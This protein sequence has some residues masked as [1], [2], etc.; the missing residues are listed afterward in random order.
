[1]QA[2]KYALSATA[3]LKNRLLGARQPLSVS[4]TVTNRCNKKCAYCKVWDTK[5]KELGTEEALGVIDELG[6]MGCQR[7]GLTGGE[8][9]LRED[10][11]ELIAQAK[12]NGIFTGLVT[13]GSLVPK[14]IEEIRAL[15]LLQVSLDGPEE[16]HDK[17]RGRGTY[18][19]AIR[20]IGIAKEE[21]LRVWVTTV[22]TK[23]SVRHTDSILDK[24]D[25]LGFTAYFQPVLDYP[26]CGGEKVRAL[27][28]EKEEYMQTIGKLIAQK[29]TRRIGNSRAGLRYLMAWPEK[30][31]QKCHAGKLFAHIYPNGNVHSCFN[32]MDKPVSCRGIG[33]REA[34]GQI[35]QTRCEGCFAYANV[36]FNLLCSMH[37]EAVSNSLELIGKSK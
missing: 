28:P 19:E 34:F 7:L 8:P 23:Y 36:E 2:T 35:E 12:K 24:A 25:E 9:L 20:A 18:K 1:M 6:A 33:F 5:E 27:Y 10:I 22:L 26:L 14:R 31:E 17:H 21:G 32:M 3:I 13:N 4:Y 11:G 16:A 30:K 37:P 29:N 15:D